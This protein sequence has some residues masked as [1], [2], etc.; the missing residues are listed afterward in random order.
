MSP[1]ACGKAQKEDSV[2]EASGY[3]KRFLGRLQTSLLNPLT[4][5]DTYSTRTAGGRRVKAE[6]EGRRQGR[7]GEARCERQGQ[8]EVGAQVTESSRALA[9]STP[10]VGTRA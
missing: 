3:L 9:G 2:F 5:M 10:V 8:R 1:G 6:A 4:T 7:E